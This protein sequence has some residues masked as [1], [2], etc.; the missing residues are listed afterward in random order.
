MKSSMKIKRQVEEMQLIKGK[1]KLSRFCNYSGPPREM[2]FGSKNWEFEK[3]KV[4]SNHTL[5]WYC[6][7]RTKKENNI[8]WHGMAFLSYVL[9]SF[10]NKT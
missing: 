8:K 7:I 1:M 4:T 3:S 2:E 6:F 9:S 10:T 5:P